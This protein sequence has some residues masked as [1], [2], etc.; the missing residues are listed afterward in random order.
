MMDLFKMQYF[1]NLFTLALIT[2]FYYIVLAM[3]NFWDGIYY[4]KVKIV[5]TSDFEFENGEQIQLQ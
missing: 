5:S 1:V 3:I 2:V 4:E